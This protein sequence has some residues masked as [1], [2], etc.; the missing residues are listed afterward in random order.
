MSE[1]NLDPRLAA[2]CE[3][4][5][6]LDLCRVLLLKDANYPWLVLVPRLADCKEIIDLSE[7][8]Q[9]LL[10]QESAMASR[11]LQA[12]FKPDKLNVAALGNMVPQLHIHHIVRYQNDA[13]WPKPVW[14]QCPAKN[15][16]SNELAERV[17]LISRLLKK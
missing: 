11:V 14:G 10:W 4:V 7:S 17:A 16:D 3:W 6:E 15:Y 12:L 8:Q 2:D 13:S 1:F 9:S 5:C